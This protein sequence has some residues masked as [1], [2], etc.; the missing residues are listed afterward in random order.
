MG[1]ATSASRSGKDVLDAIMWLKNAWDSVT[2]VTIEKCF[3]K[4]VFLDIL[5]SYR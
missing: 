4:Y 5:V 3:A 1:E 2:P